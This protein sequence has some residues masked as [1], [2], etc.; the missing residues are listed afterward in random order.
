MTPNKCQDESY[1]DSNPQRVLVMEKFWLAYVDVIVQLPVN[2]AQIVGG[3]LDTGENYGERYVATVTRP[4]PSE[5]VLLEFSRPATKSGP[6]VGTRR[7]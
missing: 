2:K 6:D 3:G 5:E 1:G 7:A 4:K